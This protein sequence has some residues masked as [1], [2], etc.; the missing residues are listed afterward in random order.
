MAPEGFTPHYIFSIRSSKYLHTPE[1]FLLTSLFAILHLLLTEPLRLLSQTPPLK[2]EA[3]YVPLFWGYLNK[4]QLIIEAPLV[5]ELAPL[6]PE[7]VAP[8]YIFSIRSSKYLHTPKKFLSTSL[9]AILHLL[10]TEPLRLL[11]QT[12]PLKGGL[13]TSPKLELSLKFKMR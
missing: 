2:G 7:G 3:C 6:A 13:V 1:N 5:G 12:P 9:F 8:H 11:S 4:L 10:L